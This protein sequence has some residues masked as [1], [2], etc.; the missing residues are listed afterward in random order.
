M[1]PGLIAL[2][3]SAALAF[4]LSA[5]VAEQ[6]PLTGQVTSPDGALEGVLVT[7][8]PVEGTV[9]VTVVSD[10]RGHYSFPAGRLAAGEHRIEIRAAGYELGNTKVTI[11]AQKTA[12]LDLKLRR[13]GDLA[14]QLSNGEW[15]L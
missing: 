4:G 13:T 7:A 1:R 10:P 15:L 9:A 5:A 14:G 12:T 6:T 3:V 8:K 2:A 11:D